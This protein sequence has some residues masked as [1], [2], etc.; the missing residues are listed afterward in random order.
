M[1]FV[2]LQAQTQCPSGAC[3]SCSG[4]SPS[5]RDSDGGL[6]GPHGSFF[7]SFLKPMP[8]LASTFDDTLPATF[9]SD[10]I[11]TRLSFRS[12]STCAALAGR[13]PE[14]G[15]A[16]TAFSLPVPRCGWWF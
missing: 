1:Y 15:G 7:Y 10:A 2:S 8:K 3:G 11:A 9:I 6:A 14:F 13:V 4:F 5:G 16:K 12:R